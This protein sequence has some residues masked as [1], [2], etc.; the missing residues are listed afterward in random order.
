MTMQKFSLVSPL[1]LEKFFSTHQGLIKQPRT[2]SRVTMEKDFS[3]EKALSF[4]F[5]CAKQVE[6]KRAKFQFVV[7]IVHKA[8]VLIFFFT[9][10][11]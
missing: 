2:C 6:E 9:S 7:E 1:P 5:L 10:K 11:H 4:T 3:P 8:V